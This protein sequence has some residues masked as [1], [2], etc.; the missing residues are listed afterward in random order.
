MITLDRYKTDGFSA[1]YREVMDSLTAVREAHPRTYDSVSPEVAESLVRCLWF[2]GMFKS[3]G[4]ETEDH[5][6][7]RV[8]SPGRWNVE[9]GPDFNGAQASIAGGPVLTGDVEIHVHAEDWAAHGHDKNPAYANVIL[10]VTLWNKHN[11]ATVTN[12]DGK[13][14]PQLGLARFLESDISELVHIVDVE[15]YPG[16]ARNR[17]GLCRARLARGAASVEWLAK[18]LDLAGDERVIVKSRDLQDLLRGRTLDRV[19]YEGI[20]EA[21]GYKTNKKP[22]KQLAQRLRLEDIRRLVPVDASPDDRALVLQGMMFGM[23]GLLPS[24]TNHDISANDEETQDYAKRLEAIWEG[25]RKSLGFQP[26]TLAD[27][28]FKSMRPVNYPTRRM[29]GMS[30]LLADHLEGGLFRAVIE[31]LERARW[32]D[33]KPAGA[34]VKPSLLDGLFAQANRGYWPRRYVFGGKKLA[35]P[36]ALIGKERARAIIVNVIIPLLLVHARQKEDQPLERKLHALYSALPRAEGNNVTRY[37]ESTLF[38]SPETAAEVVRTVRR[39]QGLYQI[40][41]DCCDSQALRCDDCVMV[42]AME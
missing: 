35:R 3:E 5:R 21:L 33:H 30:Y 26:M 1:G 9:P 24:Q 16:G 15:D 18:F 17:Q 32:S 13:P 2:D 8:L 39:Q 38:P 22:F 7:L 37:M 25:E 29:A 31:G 4:L 40:F 27:W 12:S 28:Q 41:K 6:P 10:H 14:V 42:R 34:E 20:M 23:A 19:L 36:T 11:L